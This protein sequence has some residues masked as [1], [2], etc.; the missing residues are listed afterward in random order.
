[1]TSLSSAM[2]INNIIKNNI[3]WSDDDRTASNNIRFYGSGVPT[4]TEVDYNAYFI[5]DTSRVVSYASS[6]RGWYYLTATLGFEA[7]GNIY[8]TDLTGGY[9]TTMPA[10][11]LTSSSGDYRIDADATA[12]LK[13]G[14]A[15]L[16]TYIT[17]DFYGTSR[18]SGWSVGHYEYP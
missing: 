12:F 13:T 15:N 7:N 14:G 10:S 18:T 2:G 4:G 6:N 3:F 16:S 17:T 9:F 5:K 8:D 11:G 1:M